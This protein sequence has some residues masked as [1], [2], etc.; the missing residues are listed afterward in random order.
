[1]NKL[2][3]NF[4]KI[5]KK[6]DGYKFLVSVWHKNGVIGKGLGNEGFVYR[7]GRLANTRGKF[8]HIV[9]SVTESVKKKQ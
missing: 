4:A 2:I 3:S 7:N 5:F 6:Q 1:M 9:I 8:E